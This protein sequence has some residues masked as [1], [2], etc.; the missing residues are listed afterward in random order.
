ME[1][2]PV[3]P[4][5]KAQ[6]DKYAQRHGQDA[7][8]A[9]DEVLA[10]YLEWEQHLDTLRGPFRKYSSAGQTCRSVSDAIRR[11]Q[12]TR[13]EAKLGDAG[14]FEKTKPKAT[15][16]AIGQLV[17]TN[18]MAEWPPRDTRLAWTGDL[19]YSVVK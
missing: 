17:R 6:L 18:P 14:G 10:N 9:L 2:L 3:K 13:K 16:T 1:M 15:A 8:T 5:R 4:E 19:R 7:A 12:V 11:R